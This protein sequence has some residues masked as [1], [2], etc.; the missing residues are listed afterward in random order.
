MG[1]LLQGKVCLGSPDLL[2]HRGQVGCCCAVDRTGCRLFR[3]RFVGFGGVLL[4]MAFVD[5]RS[6]WMA[7]S[8]DRLGKPG[9][10]LRSRTA[11]LARGS[12]VRVVVVGIPVA[13]GCS[14]VPRVG[15]CSL[16]G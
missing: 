13:T 4:G 1:V 9:C 7:R 6:C 11:R 15:L 10:T 3:S 12:D 2:F 16:E 14:V 5:E 8:W